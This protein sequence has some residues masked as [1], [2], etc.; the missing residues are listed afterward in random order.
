NGPGSAA[1]PF[2][3]QRRGPSRSAAQ[4]WADREVAQRT[5]RAVLAHHPRRLPDRRDVVQL[6]PQAESLARRSRGS[7]RVSMNL[8]GQKILIT[9]GASGI[10]LELAR[11]LAENNWVVIAGR[12]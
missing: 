2:T 10:G 12:N 7:H 1:R 4:Q 9:G 5:P 3:W 11:R 8:S 6:S